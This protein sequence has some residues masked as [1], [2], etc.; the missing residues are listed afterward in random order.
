MSSLLPAG[1]PRYL[2]LP[3]AQTT[4]LRALAGLQPI[5]SGVLRVNG[6][7][8]MIGRFFAGAS[9]SGRI[10]FPGGKPVRALAL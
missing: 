8:G 9:A 6:L 4:L 1:L 5:H 3:V 7:R 10:R 2:V